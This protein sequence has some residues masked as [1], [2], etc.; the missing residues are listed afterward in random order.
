MARPK[1]QQKLGGRKKGTPNVAT[2]KKEREI[3]AS[4]LTPLEY[5]LSLLRDERKSDEIR[6]EAAKAAAPYVH[7]KLAMIQHSGKDGGPIEHSHTVDAFT[8]RISGMS[9]RTG[10]G[11]GN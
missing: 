3:A 8:S 4:G 2:A 11:S 9:A 6:F 7:P 5:M 10:K 1:G